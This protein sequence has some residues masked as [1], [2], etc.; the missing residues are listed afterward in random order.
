[1]TELKIVSLDLDDVL[2]SLRPTL[3]KTI[4]K[5]YGIKFTMKDTNTYG[6]PNWMNKLGQRLTKKQAKDTF[7]YLTEDNRTARLPA[8]QDTFALC[9]F[10]VASGFTLIANTARHLDKKHY[11]ELRKQ[12]K[13]WIDKKIPG[14]FSKVAFASDYNESKLEVCKYHNCIAHLDDCLGEAIEVNQA[15]V[16]SVLLHSNHNSQ[17]GIFHYNEEPHKLGPI[18][19]DC[20]EH[21]KQYPIIRINERGD[22][23]SVLNVLCEVKKIY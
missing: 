2:V 22:F 15:G 4:H 11:H 19:E 17:D 1:M 16:L 3:F 10:L 18:L 7:R 20:I 5:L 6:V 23:L 13:V 8:F 14:L 21:R 12:T 9:N